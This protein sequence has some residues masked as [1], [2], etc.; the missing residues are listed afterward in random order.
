MEGAGDV[1]ADVLGERFVVVH[2]LRQIN[3][4]VGERREDRAAQPRHEIDQ[5][6][7]HGALQ[8]V[9]AMM[10]L[11]RRSRSVNFTGKVTLLMA[12]T[13][14]CGQH[15][16][17]AAEADHETLQIELVAGEVE[18]D[19]RRPAA[20]RPVQRDLPAGHRLKQRR[21]KVRDLEAE[22]APRR[23]ALYVDVHVERRQPG[24]PDE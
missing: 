10:R 7:D 18:L 4:A 9:L 22:R 14:S 3:L 23:L 13:C 24:S 19:Q 5:P 15:V 20:D 12:R 2:Q 8:L 17:G 6:G 11:S 21:R 16:H 1:F